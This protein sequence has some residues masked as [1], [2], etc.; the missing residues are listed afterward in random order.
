M[1]GTVVATELHKLRRAMVPPATLA[2]M[3]LGP[4]ALALFMWIV[5]DPARAARLGLIGTKAELSG[6]QA[7]WPSFASYLV[8]VI[9]TGGTVFLAFIVAYLFGREYVDGTAK[10]MLALPVGR[11]QF[12]LGKLLVTVGWWLL[13]VAVAIAEGLLLGFAL[14]LP[15][16][17][18]TLGGQLLGQAAVGAGLA[19]LLAPAVAWV[20]VAT[21]SYLASLAFAVGM[22]MV[23]NV[24]V[25]TGWAA[26]FPWSIV[27]LHAGALGG[28]PATL[29]PGSY[30]VLGL[31]AIGGVFGT[32]LQL[33]RADLS[34]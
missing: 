12:A 10:N 29:P 7:T 25:H 15:D 20:T 34:Q 30:L 16:W 9:S 19:L 8:L 26:W 33:R 2:A 18:G 27:L 21:R 6:V 17:S 23:G 11:H 14:D 32:I 3:M 31:T 4:L 5:H 24:L 1:L 13:L 28:A 22:L